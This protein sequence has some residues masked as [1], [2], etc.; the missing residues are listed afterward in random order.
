MELQ[1][2]EDYD[3]VQQMKKSFGFFEAI[4]AAQIRRAVIEHQIAK[5]RSSKPQNAN[6]CVPGA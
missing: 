5:L 4:V 2:Y 3:R 1:Y 6:R